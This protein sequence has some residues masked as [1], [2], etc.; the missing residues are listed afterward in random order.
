MTADGWSIDDLN[1]KHFRNIENGPGKILQI[2][3]STVPHL[4]S[5]RTVSTTESALYTTPSQC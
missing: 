2:E 1:Q 4:S 5:C 3:V